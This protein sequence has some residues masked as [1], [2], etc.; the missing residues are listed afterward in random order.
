MR[1]SDDPNVFVTLFNPST[2]ELIMIGHLIDKPHGQNVEQWLNDLK[3][4]NSLNPIVAEKW[5]SLNGTR[6]LKVINRNPG[7]T[8]SENIYVVRGSK[9]FA[10]G[11]DPNMSSYRVYRRM[12]STFRFTSP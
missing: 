4:I 3:G 5:I 8:Q 1:R 11:A 12:L 10:I 2:K 6:A 9:T 7:S